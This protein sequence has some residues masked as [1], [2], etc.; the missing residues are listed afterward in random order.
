MGG[1]WGSRG[2][3]GRGSRGRVR[4]RRQL[5]I[6][7]A[8]AT[9]K[10]R[11]KSPVTSRSHPGDQWGPWGRGLGG[12]TRPLGLPPKKLF[13]SPKTYSPKNYSPPKIIHLKK[14]F[15]PKN[16]SPQKNYSLPKKIIHPKNFGGVT[17]THGGFGV[18]EGKWDPKNRPQ[19]DPNQP[20][21]T[22]QPPQILPKS[23]KISPNHPKSPQ[24]P[25]KWPQNHP[26]IP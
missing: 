13:T 1:F 9:T 19:I 5:D 8:P 25:S 15:P 2:G 24:N 7:K 3:P 18:R 16:Y 20:K 17:P 21:I 14:L 26:Q 10:D 4:M 22:P 6:R 23:P 12:W 11:P